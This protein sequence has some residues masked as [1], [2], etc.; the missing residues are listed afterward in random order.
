MKTI[1]ITAI[2]TEKARSRTQDNALKK[3]DE[4][5]PGISAAAGACWFKWSSMA[6]RTQS[7]PTFYQ[8][9]LRTH[10]RGRT[11]PQS[12]LRPGGEQPR[13]CRQGHRP[14]LQGPVMKLPQ[15]T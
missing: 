12:V 11:F 10:G 7:L 5:F 4:R 3:P 14:F 9:Y 2:S 15:P 1:R 13:Q 8:M 6:N